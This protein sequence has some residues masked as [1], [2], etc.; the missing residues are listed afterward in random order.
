MKSYLKTASLTSSF[1]STKPVTTK[2]NADKK[3]P[4]AILCNGLKKLTLLL[5]TNSSLFLI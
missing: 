4:T 5:W 1:N 2:A 3:P